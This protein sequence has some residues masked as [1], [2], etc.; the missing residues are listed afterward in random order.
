MRVSFENNALDLTVTGAPTLAPLP[1]H[2]QS[3]LPNSPTSID[4]QKLFQLRQLDVTWEKPIGTLWTFMRARGRPSYNLDI[5]GDFHAW[6]RGIAAMFADDPAELRYLVL[7]SHWPGVFSL[8][9]DLN[10]FVGRIRQR[11]RDA[12][13][14]YGESC[15]RILHRNLHG[16]GM[17]MVTIGLAQGDALGG[18]FESLLSFNIII[19][20]RGAKFGFPE[21]MFG[22]F[23]GMGAHSLLTRRL[24]AAAAEEMILGGK[25]YTA[26]EMK[27]AGLVHMVVERGEGVAAVRDYIERNKRRHSGNGAIYRA[28][29]E[30]NPLALAELN[31]IV[32]IWA[33]TCLQL[34]DRDLKVMQRLVQAQDR[35]MPVTLQAAE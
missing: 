14:A 5:L 9:G 7:G 16:L 30:V 1:V 18:G 19:A 3:P 26:E 31:R 17:P 35:L 6:Q 13:I 10:H 20:E 23:P 27:D 11:D 2:S 15:V 24:G 32:E 21:T 33:D 25:M 12:L 8:G 22:L 4:A 29:R 34:R 28:S